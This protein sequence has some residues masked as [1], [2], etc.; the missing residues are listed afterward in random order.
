MQ[1]QG[2]NALAALA[3]AHALAGTDDTAGFRASVQPDVQVGAE[4]LESVSAPF[5]WG[6][7]TRRAT[8]TLRSGSDGG[9][10]HGEA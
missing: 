4:Y 8:V 10:P 6:E 5:S 7:A 1:P 9:H 2:F 3:V